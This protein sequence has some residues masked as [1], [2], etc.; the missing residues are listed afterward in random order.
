[1]C[2]KLRVEP[3]LLKEEIKKVNHGVF[4][5]LIFEEE[6]VRQPAAGAPQTSPLRDTVGL[7]AVIFLNTDDYPK[8]E[9][10]LIN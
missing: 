10:F 7:K 2:R 1:M 8:K 3:N 4:H 6:H 5:V 9:S